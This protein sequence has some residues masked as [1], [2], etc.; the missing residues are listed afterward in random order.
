MIPMTGASTF[1][2]SR[3]PPSPTS[4]TP[5]STRARAKC[6]NAIAVTHS[7]YVGCPRS[8]PSANNSS[9]ASWIRVNVSAKASSLISSPFT[10]MR[11]LIFSRCGEV[12][13]PVRNPA[14]R[15]IDSRN[16]AV[17]PFPFVPA[18]CAEGYARSGLPSRSLSVV[19]FSR[20]NFAAAACVG[21]A[22]SLP[23]DSKYLTAFSKFISIQQHVKAVRNEGLQVLPM[24]HR[25]QE[26]VFQQ[27]LRPLESFRQFLA[28]GLFDY[29]RPGKSNQRAR[30][31]DVDVAEH[32]ETRRHSSGRWVREQRNVRQFGVVQPRQCR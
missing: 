17:D 13:S 23:S 20:S 29:A 16:A 25:I 31:S 30:L 11:S 24:H 6:S 7:K 15:S 32:R 21:A 4:N 27:E 12:L 2:A 26:P 19:M 28:D 18:M 8:F 3:R 10:R 1:V 5:N 9:F 22:N 14:Q